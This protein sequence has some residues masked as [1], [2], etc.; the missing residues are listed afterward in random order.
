MIELFVFFFDRDIAWFIDWLIWTTTKLKETHSETHTY[1]KTYCQTIT[2][3]HIHTNKH[4]VILE[5]TQRHTLPHIDI[6]RDTR[7][8]KHSHRYTHTYTHIVTRRF[9]ASFGFSESFTHTFEMC[10]WNWHDDEGIREV[11]GG[12]MRGCWVEIYGL[13]YMT[14]CWP[15]MLYIAQSIHKRDFV[16]QLH[17]FFIRNPFT[18]NLALS[19]QNFLLLKVS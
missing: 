19:S 10:V 6:D 15:E 11:C 4:T 18:R 13:T 2:Y 5:H 1:T 3:T 17:S 8:S 14:L 12:G 9:I 7:Q 16:V